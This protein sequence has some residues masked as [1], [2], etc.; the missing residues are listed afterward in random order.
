MTPKP[1]FRTP[2][3]RWIAALAL[4]SSL[5]AGALTVPAVD[6][7]CEVGFGMGSTLL[8]PFFEVDLSNPA[9]LTTLF[10]INNEGASTTMV[11]VVVWSD[12][13]I[14]VLG[15]DVFLKGRDVQTIN[16]RDLLNGNL[17][18]T[19][20]DFTGFT[21]CGSV[22]PTYPPLAPLQSSQLRAYL[23]GVAGPG[24][25]QCAGEF[26]GDNHARGYITIDAVDQCSGLG[27]PPNTTPANATYF[28]NVAIVKNTLWGDAFFVDP[29][30]NSAQGVELVNIVADPALHAPNTNTFYGRYH[31]FDGRDRRS[32]LPSIW[33]TRF[34]NG[35]VFDGGTDLLVFR[36]TRSSTIARRAC[37]SHPTWYPL[38]ASSI[39]ARDED[40]NL[41]LSIGTN[42]EFELATQRRRVVD[43]GTSGPG[44]P[45]G[46]VQL[47]LQI[48]SNIPAGAWVLPVMTA[49]GRFSVDFNAQ[50]FNSACG[51]DPTP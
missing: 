8:L 42:R 28:T 37:G 7:A 10:A 11:R 46:R 1:T 38:L 24:D 33:T 43:L 45:F 14:P 16:V 6:A 25:P 15:F 18:V 40:A 2:P 51:V 19:S 9:G 21:G 49:S 48:P 23:T 17:P 39:V 47:G 27:L 31:S 35:G 22:P 29:T 12:W 32:P 41:V 44:A 30:Q 3:R 36:D 13:G 26:Y 20:G 5:A 50:P 34:L 4:A